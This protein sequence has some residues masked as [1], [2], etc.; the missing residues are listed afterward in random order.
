M[1]IDE[2]IQA[3]NQLSESDL[4]HLLHQ[5]VILRTRRKSQV[6]PEQEAQLLQIINQGVPTERC[7]H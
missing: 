2:L 7:A 1:S 5:V 3:A 6:L 4:E